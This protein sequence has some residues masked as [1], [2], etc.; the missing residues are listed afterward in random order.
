MPE[1]DDGYAIVLFC[2]PD[3]RD[4]RSAATKVVHTL[5]YARNYDEKS[6]RVKEP[7]DLGK[8]IA[9]NMAIC[10]LEE[11]AEAIRSIQFNV[12]VTS[13][14]GV[15][16]APS[17]DCGD[18][19]VYGSVPGFDGAEDI[20]ITIPDSP[21][22]PPGGYPPNFDTEEEWLAYKCQAS[23][24]IVDRLVQWLRNI[25]VL[26]AGVLLNGGAGALLI[27]MGI[28]AATPLVVLS[29]VAIAVLGGGALLIANALADEI[30]AEREDWVCAI[31]TS[32]S[33]HQAL[34]LLGEEANQ[35]ITSATLLG[36]IAARF[37]VLILGL[38][39]SGLIEKAFNAVI[40]VSYPGA[41]CS[42]CGSQE[43]GWVNFFVRNG[44]GVGVNSDPPRVAIDGHTH[45]TDGCVSNPNVWVAYFNNVA[46]PVETCV[47]PAH[48]LGTYPTLIS[49]N[50]ATGAVTVPT[51]G[52]GIW[53]I[54]DDTELVYDENVAPPAPIPNCRAVVITSGAGSTYRIRLI[55]D[56][57]VPDEVVPE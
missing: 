20:P 34:G 48:V 21:S 44:G 19:T 53:R 32:S 5:G 25:S 26:S 24:F 16:C 29:V 52:V 28:I 36:P 55:W 15:D 1:E 30:E 39:Q 12:N 41:D 10:S 43:D 14:S 37:K 40:E 54:W 7:A 46:E 57:E 18:V 27:G 47:T 6:G 35:A 42:E 51:G 22:L 56:R 45:A 17:V 38:L 23:N 8:E 4:W 3:T 33:I 50:V 9:A 13:G 31:Y 49:A 11:I 2:I